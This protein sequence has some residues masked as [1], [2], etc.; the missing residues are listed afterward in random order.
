MDWSAEAA[1][2]SMAITE[3]GQN[4]KMTVWKLAYQLREKLSHT[5]AQAFSRRFLI[6]EARIRSQG[7]PYSICGWKFYRLSITPNISTVNYPYASTSYS[8]THRTGD[9]QLGP[10][11]S[12]F[13]EA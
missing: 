11:W 12:Q 1:L 5:T 7:S 10:Q 3:G 9:R 13:H 8:I 2:S 6:A 4:F